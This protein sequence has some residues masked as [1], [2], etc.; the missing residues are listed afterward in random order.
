MGS[1]NNILVVL[2]IFCFILVF[3]L[4][5]KVLSYSDSLIIKKKEIEKISL[6]LGFNILNYKKVLKKLKEI[7]FKKEFLLESFF[8]DSLSEIKDT[9]ILDLSKDY[10]E[11]YVL[12]EKEEDILDDIDLE[13]NRRYM[14]F[15]ICASKFHSNKRILK[16]LNLIE[17]YK[18]KRKK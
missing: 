13:H 9:N 2:I 12:W 16:D 5:Y 11:P 8:M 1:I 10:I 6:D 7:L 4:I 15:L 17:R 3:C 18:I 14:R